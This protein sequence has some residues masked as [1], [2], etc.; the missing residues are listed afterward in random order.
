M[1]CYLLERDGSALDL[2][3]P[4]ETL[5][6]ESISNGLDPEYVRKVLSD[7]EAGRGACFEVLGRASGK[8]GKL[9]DL[10]Y[11][12]W[13]PA[14]SSLA[15]GILLEMGSVSA[16][17]LPC[18]L[19]NGLGVVY[20]HLPN[21]VDNI[22]NLR[23]SIFSHSVPLDPPLP[24]GA[25]HIRPNAGY[26]SLLPIFRTKPPGSRQVTPD[27]YLREDAVDGWAEKRLTGA[28]FK[29]VS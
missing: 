5:L 8:K 16:D 20:F 18:A 4:D 15:Y 14:F 9:P 26:E 19:A 17:F 29:Q 25:V 22:I 28:V 6:A 12:S 24:F 13:V 27:V 10:M 21:R 7:A 1:R 2:Y 3:L 23:E 11:W